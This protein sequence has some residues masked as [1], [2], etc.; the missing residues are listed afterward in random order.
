M[1]FFFAVWP[2]LTHFVM[3]ALQTPAAVRSKRH[4]VLAFADGERL[5]CKALYWTLLQEVAKKL[6]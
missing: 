1:R 4:L 6:Q 2:L 3:T 5:I